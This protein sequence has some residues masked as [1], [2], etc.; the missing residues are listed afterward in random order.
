MT[1]LV[2]M[3]DLVADDLLLDRLA[4][5]LPAGPEPVERLLAGLAAQADR[6]LAGRATMRRPGRRRALS[7]LAALAVGA[8]GAG[9]A[10]AVTVPD[11]PPTARAAVVAPRSAGQ[12]P[13]A[14]QPEAQRPGSERVREASDR[15]ATRSSEGWSART[16]ARFDTTGLAPVLLPAP[17]RL[18][19]G[20]EANR[21]RWSGLTVSRVLILAG[22]EGL[23]GPNPPSQPPTADPRAWAVPPSPPPSHRADPPSSQGPPPRAATRP[24]T[25]GVSQGVTQSVPQ[26]GSK[27]VRGAKAA[28]EA[29]VQ[30]TSTGRSRSAPVGRSAERAP[31]APARRG[32]GTVD[33]HVVIRE[34]GPPAGPVDPVAEPG[35]VDPVAEPGPLDPVAEPGPVDPAAPPGSMEPGPG[36]PVA[37]TPEPSSAPAGQPSGPTENTENTTE[38]T[39]DAEPTASPSADGPVSGSVVELPAPP[40]ELANAAR[41]E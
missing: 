32:A 29:R 38:N 20:S 37:A 25:Q 11:G 14:Q 19:S 33:R 40:V 26:T 10:A 21:M 18:A 8:S 16:P 17:V 15:L 27:A 23:R 6:P 13:E 2:P 12:Q 30:A 39:E 22:V 41:Y 4:G 35:L 34:P 31:V 3:S 28:G 36:A 7:A 9:V 24:A 1:G 5:R